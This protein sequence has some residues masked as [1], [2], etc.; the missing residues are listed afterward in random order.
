MPVCFIVLC[1]KASSFPPLQGERYQFVYR[2]MVIQKREANAPLT[3]WPSAF[4]YLYHFPII[5][6]HHTKNAYL[7]TSEKTYNA[8][9][10][11]VCF[12]DWLLPR[13]KNSFTIPPCLSFSDNWLIKHCN[14]NSKNNNKYKF[15]PLNHTYTL[16]LWFSHKW[17]LFLNL[18]SK[19][20]KIWKMLRL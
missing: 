10:W 17:S 15:K 8:Y 20:L 4:P 9:I 6:N 2:L 16:H 11:N 19:L 7:T 14:N 1:F 5:V 3:P 18:W 13:R 12:T